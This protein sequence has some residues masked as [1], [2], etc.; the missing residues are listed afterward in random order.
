MILQ[1]DRQV[2]EVYGIRSIDE[3]GRGAM[4]IVHQSDGQVGEGFSIKNTP[5]CIVF[6]LSSRNLFLL[7]LPSTTVRRPNRCFARSKLRGRLVFLRCS[8][9][10]AD[11]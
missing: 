2:S 9:R 6:Y 8:I 7:L 10:S 4:S 5:N 1:C 11:V 3:Y